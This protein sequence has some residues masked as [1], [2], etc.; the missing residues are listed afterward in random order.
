MSASA[1]FDGLARFTSAMTPIPGSRNAA[2]ASLGSGALAEAAL[3]DAKS[4]TD[5]RAA[6]SAF[7]PASIES[8]TVCVLMI[9][10]FL[11]LLARLRATR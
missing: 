11:T 8:R 4:I 5:S 6:T 2:W 7:T 9:N 10:P 1:P 3:M